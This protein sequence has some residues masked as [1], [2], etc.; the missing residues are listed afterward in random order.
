MEESKD[1]MDMQLIEQLF[2]SEHK[3]LCNTANRILNDWDASQDIVQE[4]F[5]KFWNKR[6]EIK[7]ETSAPA[8]LL[9]AV[10]NTCLNYLESSKRQFRLREDITA[11]QIAGLAYQESSAL[12]EKELR[13][14][15]EM[16]IERLP[17]KCKT[18]FVLCK[19]EGMKYQQIA[20]HLSISIKT[21]ENQM[22][23]ALQKL[24][25]DL[26]TYASREFLV[27]PL[28]PVLIFSLKHPII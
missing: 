14:R 16:A 19:Y 15:L 5:I 12:E 18:I 4:V 26:K 3:K 28:L 10:I 20:D 22:G 8:Y 2:R 7:I 13:I 21:V 1:R 17:P 6:N 27:W 24:R 23:I 11:E 9:K 25:E